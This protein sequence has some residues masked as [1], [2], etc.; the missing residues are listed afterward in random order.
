MLASKA[1][2]TRDQDK[3][4]LYMAKVRQKP[5]CH[6]GNAI[7]LSMLEALQASWDAGYDAVGARG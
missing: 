1:Y 6:A 5:A 3:L 7:Y 4:T 2:F